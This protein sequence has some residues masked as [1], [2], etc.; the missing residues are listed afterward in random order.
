[1]KI[2]ELFA[3]SLN[4]SNTMKCNNIFILVTCCLLV[5][6]A[7]FSIIHNPS[8]GKT[9]IHQIPPKLERKYHHGCYNKSLKLTETFLKEFCNDVSFAVG[10]HVWYNKTI[11]RLT[12]HVF[13]IP[14][15]T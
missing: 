14:E 1:M 7:V 11:G 12:L 2:N 6:G 3:L 13:K 8:Q 9:I 15:K 5:V 10:H 4:A